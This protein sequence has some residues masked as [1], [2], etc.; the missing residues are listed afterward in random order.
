MI[1]G[2][3][4]IVSLA[5][6]DHRIDAGI[7][8]DHH[9]E[10]RGTLELDELANHAR[11]VFLAFE[12]DSEL[13]SISLR[14]L[15]EVLLVQRLVACGQTALEKELLP[16]LHHAIAAVVEHDDLHW[17]IVCRHRLELADVHADAGVAIDVDDQAVGTSELGADGG[18]QTEAHRA[19][20][21][22]RQPQARLGEIE[23]LRRPHLM[24][25]HTGSDDGLTFREPVDLFDHVVR[26]DQLAVAVVV[27]GVLGA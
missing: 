12:T 25:T 18:G 2:D 24:L 19:H 9:F 3:H 10:E 26:L 8:I 11:N 15:D 5:G 14:R 13:E 6:T 27:H 22:G 21:A 4:L 20:A 7:G 16:L 17:Q 23:V 1:A